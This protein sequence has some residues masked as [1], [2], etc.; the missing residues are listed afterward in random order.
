MWL[1]AGA[2]VLG[3]VGV[4]GWG[5]ATQPGTN[6][7][8]AVLLAVLILPVGDAILVLGA[9][10]PPISTLRHVVGGFA[11]AMLLGLGSVK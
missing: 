3:A 5:V 8:M 10:Q 1:S 9:G 11:V 2:T 6:L 7:V 4:V